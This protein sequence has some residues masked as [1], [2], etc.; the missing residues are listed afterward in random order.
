MSEITAEK[1]K[2]LLV[3]KAA[4]A[5]RSDFP[6]SA[7]SMYTCAAMRMV[8]AITIPCAR[9]GQ[10]IL[11]IQSRTPGNG[12]MDVC[13]PCGLTVAKERRSAELA[14]EFR[15]LANRMR[16]ASISWTP[17]QWASHIDYCAT[18]LSGERSAQ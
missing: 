5:M 10:P 12:E 15:T 6:F 11:P 7:D 18:L 9:C 16:T 2:A 8:D 1:V 14:E 4:Q 17:G 13:G 3:E